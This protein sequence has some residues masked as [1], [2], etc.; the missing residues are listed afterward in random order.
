MLF[1]NLCYGVYFQGKQLC[2]LSVLPFFSVEI[3]SVE[4]EEYDP[5]REVLSRVLYLFGYETGFSP[6]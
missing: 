2:P 1:K 4:R 5:L 3:I 6:V